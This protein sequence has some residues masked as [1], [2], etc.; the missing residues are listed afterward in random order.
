[1]ELSS[2]TFPGL[3]SMESCCSFGR[4]PSNKSPIIDSNLFHSPGYT[5]FPCW[6]ITNQHWRFVIFILVLPAFMCIFVWCVN[7]F[8]LFFISFQVDI[9]Q[10]CHCQVDVA[11]QVIA[12]CVIAVFAVSFVLVIVKGRLRKC[13][14]LLSS[15][16][17]KSEDSKETE[18]I[19]IPS[20]SDK[21]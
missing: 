20:L 13:Q 1:V 8:I 12:T 6:L 5:S 3:R 16:Y 9:V 7:N 17:G 14:N 18:A 11:S 19:E 15:R 4:C 10:C 21:L 2:F